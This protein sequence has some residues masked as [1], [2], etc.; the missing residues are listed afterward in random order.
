MIVSFARRP[1]FSAL[2]EES[3][4]RFSLQA[5]LAK[6][7]KKF[8]QHLSRDYC[9]PGHENPAMGFFWGVDQDSIVDL[10]KKH[11]FLTKFEPKNRETL[12]SLFWSKV[13]ID[14]AWS[15]KSGGNP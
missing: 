4:R 3:K 10:L 9:P 12:H 5:R 7:R 13:S 1:D 15:N 2:K 6:N 8:G 14:R 11:I